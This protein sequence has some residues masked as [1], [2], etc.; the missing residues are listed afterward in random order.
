LARKF[1]EMAGFQKEEIDQ[2][3]EMAQAQRDQRAPVSAY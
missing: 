2:I 3:A 1:R